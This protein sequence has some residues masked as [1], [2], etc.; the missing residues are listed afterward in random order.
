[1]APELYNFVFLKKERIILANKHI[2]FKAVAFPREHGSWGFV[3][4]PLILAVIVAYNKSGLFIALSAFFTFLAH[5]PIRVILKKGIS[6]ELKRKAVWFLGVYFF[7]SAVFIIRVIKV[8]DS[9][10]LIPL[11]FVVILMMY[12]LYLEIIGLSRN[13]YAELI[14][15][16]S[17]N[18]IAFSIVL[19]DGWSL[20][21]A[22]AFLVVLLNRSVPTTFFIH[23]KLN[24]IK[25][26]KAKIMRTHLISFVGLIAVIILAVVS[27]VP[28]L[29]LIAVLILVIREIFGFTEYTEKLTVKQIGMLEFLYGTIFVIINAVGYLTGL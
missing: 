2:N 20:P 21:S 29:S 24:L 5:Q 9:T 8:Q 28:Y 12:F 3:L 23:E 17:M 18:L 7:L 27:L 6:K 19:T 4:E 14:G 22:F 10:V 11:T 13:V 16:V 15:P 1:M 25:H 26:Q